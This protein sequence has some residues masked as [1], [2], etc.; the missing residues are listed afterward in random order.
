LP[1]KSL[2]FVF[3]ANG[4]AEVIAIYFLLLTLLLL[5]IAAEVLPACR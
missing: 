5:L 4:I 3:A 1:L 2:L